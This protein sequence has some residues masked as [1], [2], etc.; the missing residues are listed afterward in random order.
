MR[1]CLCSLQNL[2]PQ[3]Q[4]PPT[5]TGL[6]S[7]VVLAADLYLMWVT[8]L[9][10]RLDVGSHL[11][12]HALQSAQLATKGASRFCRTNYINVSPAWFAKATMSEVFDLEKQPVPARSRAGG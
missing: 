11:A 2:P 9:A 10:L 12:V 6:V 3:Q 7:N 8:A 1:G 4:L 5:T